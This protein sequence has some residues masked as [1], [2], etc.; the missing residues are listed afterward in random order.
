MHLG[1]RI[2]KVKRKI[3]FF[4]VFFKCKNDFGNFFSHALINDVHFYNVSIIFVT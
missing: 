2:R 3:H 1:R 4:K